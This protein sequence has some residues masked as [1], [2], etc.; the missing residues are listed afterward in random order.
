M[1]CSSSKEGLSVKHSLYLS[2]GSNLGDRVQLLHSAIRLL[3]EQVGRV[4]RISEFVETEPLGFTSSNWFMNAALRVETEL[5]PMQ[6][7]ERTQAIEQAL[8]RRHKSVDGVY[9]DR[10]ID[11]DLL[12]YDELVLEGN[13]L[14][15]PHPRM[16]LRPFVLEP[17]SEIAPELRHPLLGKSIAE[18]RRELQGHVA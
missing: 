15:L 2:L 1:P 6:V 14:S 10:P 7:L 5:E 16:H 13:R 8:G 18:L 11:I 3:E 17:L 9:S 4:E 12:L